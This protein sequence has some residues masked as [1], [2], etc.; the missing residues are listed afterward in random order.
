MTDSIETDLKYIRRD[1]DK[2]MEKLDKNYV[3]KDEFAPVQKIVYG[4][5]TLILTG[6]V[7]A[8]LALVVRQ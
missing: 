2:I 8:L 4:L 1:L 5:V 3:T 6:V 7:L